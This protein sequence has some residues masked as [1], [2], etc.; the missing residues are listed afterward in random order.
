MDEYKICIAVREKLPKDSGVAQFRH[1][2]ALVDRLKLKPQA[3]GQHN[4]LIF[5]AELSLFHL[6]LAV[7]WLSKAK[8]KDI[9][10]FCL[11]HQ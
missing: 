5:K 6:M 2:D 10:V 11:K 9:K 8:S 4:L 3:K 1:Y 7:L